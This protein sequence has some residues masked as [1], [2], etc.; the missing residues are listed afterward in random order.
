[1]SNLQT[2]R[3][4]LLACTISDFAQLKCEMF[5][6]GHDSKAF[7]APLVDWALTANKP[8]EVPGKLASERHW[9]QDI[10]NIPPATVVEILTPQGRVY[11]GRLAARCDRVYSRA[12]TLRRQMARIKDGRDHGNTSAVAWRELP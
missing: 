1:M 11:T 6:N 3:Q 5:P 4:A 9:R 8:R 2:L 10:R 7:L 12:G